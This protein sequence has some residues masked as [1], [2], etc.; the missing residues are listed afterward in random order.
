MLIFPPAGFVVKSL[1]NTESYT[2][3]SHGY[4]MRAL[5]LRFFENLSRLS[6][7]V[8]RAVSRSEQLRARVASA[9]LALALSTQ[10]GIS[11]QFRAPAK[12]SAAATKAAHRLVVQVNI[13]DPAVMNLALNNVSNVA[14]H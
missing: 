3:T 11:A 12:I 8:W 7:Y 5:E 2:I 4:R 13:N 14:Q 9:A 1:I 6:P 10:I